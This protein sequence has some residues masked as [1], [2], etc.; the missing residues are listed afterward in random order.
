MQISVTET[1]SME[2]KSCGSDSHRVTVRNPSHGHCQIRLGRS[3]DLHWMAKAVGGGVGVD[4][5]KV[6]CN[7]L[8]TGVNRG[9]LSGASVWGRTPSN[10]KL[11]LA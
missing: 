1:E 9:K 6:C 10:Y 4:D 2:I 7:V 3:L 5:R 11:Y 8:C